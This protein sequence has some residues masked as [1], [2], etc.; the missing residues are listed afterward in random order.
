MVTF[1]VT[2]PDAVGPN[3]T[4]KLFVCEAASVSGTVRPLTLNPVPLTVTLEIVKPELPVFF[5][6]TVCEFVVPFATAPK[7]TL[8]GVADSVAGMAPVPL[9]E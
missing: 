1:P 3:A 8:E 5:N 4:V 9:N 6:W 2:L 7:L